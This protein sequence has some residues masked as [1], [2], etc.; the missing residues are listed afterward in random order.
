MYVMLIKVCSS[1]TSVN[2]SA[3]GEPERAQ[4]TIFYS[5]QV[6][7]FNDFPADKA[8]EVMQLASKETSQSHTTHANDPIRSTSSF[9][10]HFTRNSPDSGNS[11]PPSPNVVPNF[12]NQ[13]IQECIQPP[14]RPVAC[15]NFL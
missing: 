12:G 6:I 7:V 13:A 9:P 4:M 8:K 15:G 5:G 1:C 2:K 10:S 3:S 14:S 11:I